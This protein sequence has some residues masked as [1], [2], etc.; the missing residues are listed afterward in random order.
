V[1]CAFACGGVVDTDGFGDS[2][3]PSFGETGLGDG[4]GDG[5]PGCSEHA[6][7]PGLE[8]C[9]ETVCMPPWGMFWAANHENDQLGCVDGAGECEL[10]WTAYRWDELA[11]DWAESDW[12]EMTEITTETRFRLVVVEI[13]LLFDDLIADF[14]FEGA[15]PLEAWKASEGAFVVCDVDT[16]DKT[17]DVRFTLLY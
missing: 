8:A 2:L 17:T 5:D 7:C 12:Y 1:A 13:D 14:R 4:D 16:C 10:E 9:D 11:G 15:G 3:D 6:E